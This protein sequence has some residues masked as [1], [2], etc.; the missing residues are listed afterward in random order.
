MTQTSV[1]DGAAV[2][3]L[4]RFLITGC[5]VVLEDRIA[6]GLSVAISGNVIEE[7]SDT[8]TQE[9]GIE[10]IDVHGAFVAPGFIDLQV[11]GCGGRLFNNSITEETL[12][13]MHRANLRHGTTSFFPTLITAGEGE[14]LQALEVVSKLHAVRKEGVAGIHLEGP[15]IN[16]LRKGIHD[17]KYIRQPSREM[18]E[19]ITYFAGQFPVQLTL[20]PE[21]VSP[22][23]IGTLIE[24]GVI[25]SCGHSNATYEEATAAFRR[26]IKHVTHLC[27]AM[28]PWTSREPGVVGA[29]LNSRDVYCSVIADGVHVHYG[30]LQLIKQL[31]QDKCYLVSDAVDYPETVPS[32]FQF[33]GQTIVVRDGRCVNSEGRLG[34]ALTG[35]MELV[36]NVMRY[37]DVT[38][39]EAVRMASLYP[40]QVAGLHWHIGKIA[41]GYSANMVVFDENCKIQSVLDQGEWISPFSSVT[42]S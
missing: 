15:Y 12:R 21:M 27:N 38:I 33:G 22:E 41:P 39:F 11:N 9:A 20:A 25:V 4:H 31:K 14:M 36:Q 16:P 23:T 32:S 8:P 13:I 17:E 7:V 37:L 18:L 34:G 10:K 6:T 2:H 26:G 24:R 42:R 29:C 30:S 28:S 35:M 40:A 19:A 3:G 1:P 5:R